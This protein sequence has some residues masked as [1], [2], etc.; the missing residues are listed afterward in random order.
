ME[1]KDCSTTADKYKRLLCQVTTELGRFDKESTEHKHLYRQYRYRALG[2]TALATVLG[3]A[4]I[5][6]PDYHEAV[7]FAIVAVTAAANVVVSVESIRKPSELWLLE[8]RIFHMLSD[9]R[10][11]LEYYGPEG[12]DEQRLDACFTQLQDVLNASSQK[13]SQ[14]IKAGQQPAAQG[15][16]TPP[17]QQ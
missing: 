2:L 17:A 7:G 12:F 16:G 5:V 14:S 1:T 10:R 9:M 15:A 11:E 3:S 13:W 8:R 4:S 6:L